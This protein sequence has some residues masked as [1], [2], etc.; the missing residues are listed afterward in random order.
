MSPSIALSTPRPA[1]PDSRKAVYGAGKQGTI[2]S[3]DAMPKPTTLNGAVRMPEGQSCRQGAI[4]SLVAM[5][6]PTTFNGAVWIAMPEVSP[7]LGFILKHN[8]KICNRGNEA[9]I[10]DKN[11]EE[12]INITHTNMN[13]SFILHC[14]VPTECSFSDH[15]RTIYQIS[16]EELHQKPHR[17][18]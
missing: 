2:L 4:L 14:K 3:L 1:R 8:L 10:Q 11:R 18:P 5:P 6:T 13:E 12:V 9:S 16:V 15:R 17:N 7:F